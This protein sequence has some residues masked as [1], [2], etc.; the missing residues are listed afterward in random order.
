ML[1]DEQGQV[2]REASV[3][4]TSWKPG[5]AL[6]YGRSYQW[7]VEDASSRA[8]SAH[9]AHKTRQAKYRATEA[10]EVDADNSKA[11]VQF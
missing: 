10:I 8:V 5:A 6:G 4:G 2:L 9:V 7:K 1:M 3:N 11:I